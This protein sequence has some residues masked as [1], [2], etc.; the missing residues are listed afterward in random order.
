MNINKYTEK[1]QEAIIGAQ[2]LADGEGHPEILPEHLLL[3]LLEQR[4]GIVPEIVRKMNADPAQLASAVRAELQKLPR[5]HGGTQ[6]GLSPRLRQVTTA[7][8]AEAE[9]LKDEYVSTEHL[10]VAIASEPGRSP[11]ARL[12]TDRGLDPERAVE[13]REFR[14]WYQPIVA[15]DKVRYAGDPVAAVAA[16]GTQPATIGIADGRIHV[17]LD[18]ARLEYL[19]TCGRATKLNLSNLAAHLVP[20][21][22]G[23]TT[24]AATV[25]ATARA[26]IRV[27]ATG[28]IGGVHRGAGETG[29]ISADITALARFP[30]AVVCAGAKA[31]LD[32]PRTLELLETLGV[33]V[34]GFQTGE[35]PAFYSRQSGLPVDARFD[36]VD[37]LAAAVRAHFGLEIGTG[38][39]VANPIP[40]GHELPAAVWQPAIERALSGLDTSKVL[41]L[42][43]NESGGESA[44]TYNYEGYGY[45]A[46]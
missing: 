19:A 14:V 26:G 30:V 31:V 32:L 36:S 41:G 39:V 5:A 45:I 16:E 46:G 3:T 8:E 43:L 18:R 6:V 24:V 1:A 35:F 44:D 20:G 10:L 15:L 38:V 2:Q 11:A 33:P 23:S 13:R 4:A 40:R 12:L 37:P 9:R 25:F 29:D 22:W 7:A 34:F 27:M 21:S 42:V 28:G 17:G